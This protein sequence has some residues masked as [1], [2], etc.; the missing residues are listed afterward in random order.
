M[1]TPSH[2]ARQPS[3]P[4]RAGASPFL[5]ASAA[6]SR[7]GGHS[8]SHG[9]PETTAPTYTG[10]VTFDVA[11]TKLN[12]ITV[13][14]AIHLDHL[15]I[16]LGNRRLADIDRSELRAWLHHP[17]GTFIRDDT[18]FTAEPPHLTITPDSG[19]TYLFSTD[20][21]LHLVKTI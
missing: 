3:P 9:H 4:F 16:W 8:H 1:T 17:V 19:T 15:T 14:V 11:D 6:Q 2:Q 18:A 21:T 20:D 10:R 5:R 12:R 7:I 13:D